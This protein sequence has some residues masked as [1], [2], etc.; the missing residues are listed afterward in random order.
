MLKFCLVWFITATKY[1]GFAFISIKKQNISLMNFCGWILR[2]NLV[3]KCPDISCLSYR[4]HR[5]KLPQCYRWG[6]KNACSWEEK[7]WKQHWMRKQVFNLSRFS[8]GRA[9]SAHKSEKQR[10]LSASKPWQGDSNN[11]HLL[12][13]ATLLILM[14]KI[15]ERALQGL[16]PKS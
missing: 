5:L 10:T 2:K 11:A 7:Q 9:S 4:A 16:T 13:P 14:V 1:V 6:W 15:P 3:L 8:H 12:C